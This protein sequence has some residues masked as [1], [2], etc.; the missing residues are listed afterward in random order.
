[1]AGIH[2][3]SR[4]HTHTTRSGMKMS[5]TGDQPPPITD[6]TRVAIHASTPCACSTPPAPSKMPKL[7]Q[8]APVDGATAEIAGNTA[9]SDR[10]RD[11]PDRKVKDA[12]PMVGEDDQ[13]EERAQA[14]DRYRERIDRDEIA[15][16]W[17]MTG[18]SDLRTERPER[19]RLAARATGSAS[20]GAP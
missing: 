7:D 10:E 13:D 14:S 6:S 19:F 3:T 5:S 17:R 8:E 15:D 12:A 4:R 1:V 9:A 18:S 20:L 16:V 11:S 2:G